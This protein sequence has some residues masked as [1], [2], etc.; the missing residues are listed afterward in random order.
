MTIH[1]KAEV[2]TGDLPLVFLLTGSFFS[3]EWLALH[4]AIDGVD[5]KAIE[6]ARLQVGDVSVRVG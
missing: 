5:V 1:I 3:H 2:F 6:R 4:V